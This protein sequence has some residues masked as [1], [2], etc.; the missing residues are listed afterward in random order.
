MGKSSKGKLLK[1]NAI[2][3]RRLSR[4]NVRLIADKRPNQY[5]IRTG[6]EGFNAFD[7]MQREAFVKQLNLLLGTDIDPENKE[8]RKRLIIL[9]REM[10]RF[11]E[12]EEMPLYFRLHSF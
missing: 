12:D 11:G 5:S 6:I 10:E 7:K 1:F 3:D 2:K 8:L 4:G 9:Q